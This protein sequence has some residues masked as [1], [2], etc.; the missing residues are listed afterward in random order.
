M[1]MSAYAADVGRWTMDASRR[2]MMQVR[3]GVWEDVGYRD[4]PASE[5]EY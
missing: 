4:T 2:G 1:A 3:E 5:I